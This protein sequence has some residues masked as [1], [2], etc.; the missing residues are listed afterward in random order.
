MIHDEQAKALAESLLEADQEVRARFIRYP[1]FNPR[2]MDSHRRDAYL[3]TIKLWMQSVDGNQ[4]S[5]HVEGRS[6]R[7]TA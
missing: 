5:N 6:P 4:Q 1:Q 3:A 7:Q 2:D